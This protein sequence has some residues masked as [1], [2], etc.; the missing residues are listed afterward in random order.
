MVLLRVD[1][2][3]KLVAVFVRCAVVCSVV[4]VKFADVVDLVGNGLELEGIILHEE[5]R[6]SRIDLD[7]CAVWEYLNTSPSREYGTVILAIR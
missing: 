1:T 4:V 2:L 3:D 5:S 7:V 6:S